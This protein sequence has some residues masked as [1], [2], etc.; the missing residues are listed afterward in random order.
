MM[1]TSRP[2]NDGS[3]SAVPATQCNPLGY[4]F[5]GCFYTENGA[6]FPLIYNDTEG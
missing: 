6:V 5:A 4:N 2:V 1:G 3:D